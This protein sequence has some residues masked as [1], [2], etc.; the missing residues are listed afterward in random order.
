VH[1]TAHV[2]SV[3]ASRH[4]AAWILPSW[5]LRWAENFQIGLGAERNGEVGMSDDGDDGVAA[6]ENQMDL[7]FGRL[8]PSSGVHEIHDQQQAH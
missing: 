6:A 4:Q 1:R 2:A 7:D 3:P 8:E 5:D